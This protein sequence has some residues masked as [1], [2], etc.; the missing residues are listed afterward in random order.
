LKKI[1]YTIIIKVI[2]KSKKLKNKIKI[3]RKKREE[4]K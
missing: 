1:N 3:N 2:K 4:K